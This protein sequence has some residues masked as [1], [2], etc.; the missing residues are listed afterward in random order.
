MLPL[1]LTH[2]VTLFSATHLQLRESS[3]Y[4]IGVG[5]SHLFI[6]FGVKNAVE[7]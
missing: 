3:A 4:G 2:Y 5:A 7:S 1:A 6:D